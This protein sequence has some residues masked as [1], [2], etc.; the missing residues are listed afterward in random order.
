MLHP[1]LENLCATAKA[2]RVPDGCLSTGKSIECSM[3]LP[4][5]DGETSIYRLV[6][7]V[8]P[9]APRDLAV[10]E[11]ASHRRLPDGCP[12]RHIN[13]DGT[14]CLGWGPTAPCVPHSRAEA[15]YVWS[16][17]AGYLHL[18]DRATACATWPASAEWPHGN[19]AKAQY[20]L[21]ELLK[22]VPARFRELGILDL[23][24][25]TRRKECP[26]G[27]HR[28]VKDCHEPEL[29][30]VG[31]LR[32]EVSREGDLFWRGWADRPCCGTMRNCRLTQSESLS[33][34]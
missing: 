30:N 5:Y 7:S 4:L 3:H 19:A 11:Q 14:F 1:A 9:G 26:C 17:I 34:G 28:R 15:E 33:G 27:S 24:R 8:R 12:S 18:Q 25:L 29:A 20:E 10:R 21:E 16:L 31:R 22:K 6:I 2:P 23:E 13:Q 32:R